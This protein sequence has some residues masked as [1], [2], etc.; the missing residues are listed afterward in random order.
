MHLL[1]DLFVA[2]AVLTP[3]LSFAHEGQ[4]PGSLIS[5]FGHVLTEPDHLAMVAG[6]AALIGGAVMLRRAI[7]KRKKAVTKQAA[8]T[9][10]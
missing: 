6:L 7:S 9:Q 1:K 8:R 4:H 10:E 3:S 5:G 2:A